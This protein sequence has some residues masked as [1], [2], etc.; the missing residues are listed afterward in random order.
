MAIRPI[1]TV[2]DPVLRSKSK[3]VSKVDESVLRLIDDMLE[4]MYESMGVG[5]AAPQ[6][7]VSKQVVIFDIGEGPLCLINPVILTSEGEEE[8]IEG[9]LSVPARERIIPRA[10]KITVKA[11]DEN[12]KERIMSFAGYPARVVQHELDHL[13]GKLIIDKGREAVPEE[14]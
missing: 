1:R 8:D 13:E 14:D 12:G 10:Y 3:P 4:T 7:G 5:L 11:L 9:C 2:G 6:I